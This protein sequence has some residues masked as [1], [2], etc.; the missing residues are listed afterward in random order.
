MKLFGG[1]PMH[2]ICYGF[3]DAV[4]GKAINYYRCRNGLIWLASS[5]WGWDRMLACA[6]DLWK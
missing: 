2:F 1:R 3:T 4:S 6:Q 5:R